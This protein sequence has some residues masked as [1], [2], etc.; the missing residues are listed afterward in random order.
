[1]QQTELRY[2]LALLHIPH[3]GPSKF[4]SLLKKFP[5]LQE[6]FS[7]SAQQLDHLGLPQKIVAAI[8]KPCWDAV[9]MDL[10][11]AQKEHCF[12]LPWTDPAYPALLREIA[13][14]PPLLYGQGSKEI[15]QSFQLA[16]VGSRNPTVSGTELAKRFASD[17]SHMGFTITSGLALGID[18]AS[19]QGALSATGQTIAVL[20]SGLEQIYPSRHKSL[21]AA[22][23]TQGVL[24]S[25]HPPATP[26][27]AENFPRRNRIISGLTRGVLVIE[28]ALQS[29][30]LITARTAVEQGREVFAIPGSIHNPLAKGCHAL[31]RQGAKLVE[32]T[33]DILDEFSAFINSDAGKDA[34]PQTYDS[35]INES[36]L[37]LL[38]CLGYE[39]TSIDTLIERSGLSS[40]LLAASLLALELDGVI[41]AVPG[42]FMRRG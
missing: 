12:I 32:T 40:H 24:I 36:H 38:A 35:E 22:I 3:I 1:M 25:E 10:A 21:A 7:L 23:S 31:I 33:A 29:G 30:S 11:W 42:G 20:G 5:Q 28:A 16:M 15:L 39:P 14:A 9:D 18:A 8:K 17:L 19:H 26:P 34:P 27:K 4:F 2:W 37:Q 13:S 41:D 6:L